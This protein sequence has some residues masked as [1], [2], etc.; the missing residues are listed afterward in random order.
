MMRANNKI[1]K[2]A[3]MKKLIKDLQEIR[4]QMEIVNDDL[5]VEILLEREKGVM[6]RL[7]SEIK[8]NKLR[9]GITPHNKKVT[10]KWE[11]KG[12][13]T[14]NTPRPLLVNGELIV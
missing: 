4:K 6:E 3:I 12:N 13:Q 9:K 11:N 1:S 10:F 5:Q 14:I 2:G 7:N 8:V